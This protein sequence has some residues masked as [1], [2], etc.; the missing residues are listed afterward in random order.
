MPRFDGPVLVTG[1]S[2]FLGE[3]LARLLAEAGNIV[4]GTNHHNPVAI[5]RVDVIPVDL[6]DAGSMLR[7]FRD[8]QPA[9][10]FHCAALTD[11]NACEQD[12]EAAQAINVDGT[13]NLC[14]A[15]AQHT[16]QARFVYVSTDLAFDGE[17]A[18]YRED[19]PPNPLGAY[20]RTKVEGEG[21]VLAHPRGVVVRAPLIYGPTGTH[22]GGF[23][24]WME[25]AV[26]EGREMTL[27]SD[28][29]RSPVH[30]EDLCV[31]LAFAARATD[32]R[33][34][35]HAAGLDR[36][37]RVEMGKLLCAARGK[38]TTCI[39]E[40]TR[41]D[42]GVAHLRPRDVTLDSR[43]L[44]EAAGWEPRGFGKGIETDFPTFD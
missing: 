35:W 32:E 20:G 3:H 44:W 25:G 29:T 31:G 38:D 39:R 40:R 22:S 27:F 41:A 6:L 36:L 4:V 15:A 23:L 8:L 28:E 43:R 11:L 16:P 33:R 1:A 21:V 19:D 14:E 5:P 10:V 7:L 30:V 18:P 12:P 26:A 2:G 37:S 42:A 17:H 9:A 34:V 13:R 24:A